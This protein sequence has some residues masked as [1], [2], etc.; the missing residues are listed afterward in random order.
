MKDF[1][2]P[3][4]LPP[5]PPKE[6]GEPAD[7]YQWEIMQQMGFTNEEIPKF[8][9][10][11]YW[12]KYF[13]PIAEID[14]KRF[15]LACDFRRSFITTDANP[16][17]DSFIRWQFTVLKSR[18]NKL[19]FGTRPSIYSPFDDQIC[20]DH[21]RAKGEGVK[22][23]EYSIIKLKVAAPYPAVFQAFQN[24]NIFLAAATLRPETMYGQTNV[25]LKPDGEYVAI[26]ANDND[27]LVCTKRSADN[28]AWQNLTKE[29]KKVSVVATF[30]GQELMGA[31]IE[32][33]NAPYKI[34]HVLPML[35]ID[36]KKTTG[37]VTSVP[38]DSPD[39]YA[40][41]MDLK[42]KPKLRE[43]YNIKDEHVLPFEV[44]PIINIPGHAAAIAPELYEKFKIQSQ[45]DPKLAEAK[46]IAYGEGFSLGVMNEKCGSF[47]GMPVK[48][49][50]DKIKQDLTDRNLA[51]KYA[52]PES[53][54][55]SRSGDVCVVALTDQWF[56]N[57]GEDAWKAQIDS[58]I[59]DS[60][61][62]FKTWSPAVRKELKET[63]DWLREWGCS[64]S[65]G[66]GTKLPWDE[67]YLIES[68][69]DSTI[70][71][72]YYTVA[73]LLHTDLNGVNA[74]PAVNIKPEQ[75]T[76]EAWDYVFLGAAYPANANVPSEDA[77]KKLK[78]EFDYWYPVNL[79]VSGKDLIKNHLTM[80]LYNHAAMWP[81]QKEKWPGGIFANGY[82]MVEGEKMSKSKGNFLTMEQVC[83]EY[84]ADAT[85]IALADAGDSTDDA[86]F[87][88]FTANSSIL[89][90]YTHLEWI[91]EMVAMKDKLRTGP[92]AQ[93]A[94]LVFENKINQALI[95]CKQNYE[96]M[97]YREVLK[98]AWFEFESA[99]DEYRLEVQGGMH[100]DL[101][102]RWIEACAIMMAPITPHISEYIWTE[103]LHNKTNI[104]NARYPDVSGL[105]VD[106]MMLRKNAYLRNVLHDA[107]LKVTKEK[108]KPVSALLYVADKFLPWQLTALSV[109]NAVYTEKGN[110]DDAKYITAKMK[111]QKMDNKV[112]GN[113]MAFV[114][115][116]Q[117]EIKKE[118][119][120]CLDNQ[121]PFDECELLYMSEAI[122]K[123]ALNGIEF[124]V[125]KTSDANVPD[126]MKRV[127][128]ARP[129]SPSIAFVVEKK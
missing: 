28:M 63:V 8:A 48:E 68:L 32:A 69:S 47:A 106:K 53:L 26:E 93:F 109:L 96:K 80:F 120:Q 7:K 56:L 65:F 97:L 60:N 55:I 6:D 4:N 114:S 33:P 37:V 103:I 75:M 42:N 50:K 78:T 14:L 5:R 61:P 25:W 81:D 41:L 95:D 62:L 123:Q 2:N 40:A 90:L 31:G 18:N 34:V 66:L 86:N 44:V 15:G 54:V 13:P 117:E 118:G 115:A 94:D 70:Y 21:D 71:M 17:Y 29:K 116:K 35:T 3:P 30:M 10:G 125:Y 45:N 23:K 89:R 127:Q 73:H 98:S 72:A 111:E 64:R 124:K 101:V 74:N 46:D 22:P 79:R 52:E 1:G 27:L 19:S 107:R 122:L 105:S 83:N 12:L 128:Q 49:A 104:V 82:I 9:D 91:K 100:V 24:K 119:V 51:A 59:D 85:R 102:F 108:N 88:V 76:K 36:M 87:T 16:Y 84:S 112:M 129:G 43:K 20:A 39:D 126:P 77:L 92:I 67:R 113:A 38:S 99:R 58:W 110:I 121:V 11:Y 57:Y